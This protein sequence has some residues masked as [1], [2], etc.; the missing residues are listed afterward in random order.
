MRGPRALHDV[1]SSVI[2][3]IDAKDSEKVFELGEQIEVA[4]E[5]CHKQVLV[6]QRG[7]PALSVG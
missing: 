7:D 1:V 5:N 4:C 6:S 2:E 3:A